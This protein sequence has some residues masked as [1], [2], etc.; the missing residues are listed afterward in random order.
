MKHVLVVEDD[1]DILFIYSH[2]LEGADYKVDQ[3]IDGQE[4]IEKIDANTYDLVLLDIMLPKVTGIDVLKH[5]RASEKA[6][7]TP[8]YLLTNISQEPIIQQCFKI[9]AQGYIIKTQVTPAD[10]VK[11]LDKFFEKQNNPSAS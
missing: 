6:K 10:V 3:A 9:G 11:E 1:S 5:I 2:A 8:V 7:V 4:A